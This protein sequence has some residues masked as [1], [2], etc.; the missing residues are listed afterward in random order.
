MNKGFMALCTNALSLASATGTLDALAEEL[1][2]SQPA[3]FKLIEGRLSTSMAKVRIT[4]S[5][6]LIGQAPRWAG[7]MDEI[8]AAMRDAGL[9]GG[10]R[11]FDGAAR[12]W[13]HV[14]ATEMCVDSRSLLL[15]L[16]V[17]KSPSSTRASTCS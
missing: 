2:A 10:A 17:V 5:V 12:T 3:F 13:E 8:S 16:A 11:M 6:T 1:Q 4:G 15:M 14:G 9:D 7:E